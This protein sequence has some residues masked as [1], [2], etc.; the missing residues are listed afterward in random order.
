MLQAIINL[1]IVV[2]ISLISFR[3]YEYS[4]LNCQIGNQIDN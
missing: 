4:R 1:N 2:I 3:T